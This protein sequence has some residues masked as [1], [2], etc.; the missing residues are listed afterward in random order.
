[1]QPDPIMAEIMAAASPLRSGDRLNAR[2][3]LQA[4]W[5]KIA[6]DALPIHE[7]ALAHTMADAQDDPKEELAWDLRALEAAKRCTDADAQAHSQAFSISAFMPSLHVNLAEDYFKLGD[8]GLSRAH[9]DSARVFVGALAAD[10][11]GELIRGGIERMAARLA[12]G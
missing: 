12:E 11:Y 6:A 3:G 9:L 5:A 10:S 7:V 8:R 4:V 1:M 2:N